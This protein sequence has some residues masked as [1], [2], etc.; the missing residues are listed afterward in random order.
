[1]ISDLRESFIA[2][3]DNL[4]WMDTRTKKYAKEKVISSK[5]YPYIIACL[6]LHGVMFKVVLWRKSHLSYWIHLKYKQVV[7]MIRKMPFTIF[8]YL[9][10][11]Q[12]Y[13][14]FKICKLGKSWRHILN[15]VLIEYKEKRYISQFVS[16]MFDS[17]QKDSTK[18]APQ[19]E[20]KSCV[21]MATYRVPDLPDIKAISGHL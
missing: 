10:S 2:N 14:V 6:L 5:M 1:M 4:D 9:F 19:Y 17:L 18:R 16:E 15:Q 11:F 13:Q 8:K 3:L 12:R 7:C 21:T 20:L